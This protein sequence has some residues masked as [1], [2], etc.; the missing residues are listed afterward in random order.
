[1]EKDIKTFGERFKF[2]REERKLTKDHTIER[3][4]LDDLKEL[5]E[6]EDGL[7]ESI[8]PEVV[9]LLLEVLRPE[10]NGEFE[11]IAKE[12]IDLSGNPDLVSEY[13]FDLM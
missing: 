8:A 13:N 7:I 10:S 3:A 5:E 12:L 11:E 6:I 4:C 1:M 9:G 2:L